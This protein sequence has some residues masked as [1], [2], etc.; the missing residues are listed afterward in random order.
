LIIIRS[1]PAIG[2]R[3]KRPPKRKSL[4]A[5][6]IRNFNRAQD[7]F[8]RRRKFVRY[9][10][11]TPFTDYINNPNRKKDFREFVESL[12]DFRCGTLGMGE[13]KFYSLVA[14]FQLQPNGQYYY[15][16]LHL[17][18]CRGSFVADEY[19]HRIFSILTLISYAISED[20]DIDG[21]VNFISKINGLNVN[22]D[23]TNAGMLGTKNWYCIKAIQDSIKR[24][25]WAEEEFLNKVK[26]FYRSRIRKVYAEML[27]MDVVGGQLDSVKEKVE[28]KKKPKHI[29]AI[30]K[31][32]WFQE[33]EAGIPG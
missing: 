19:K 33:W 14:E 18:G 13:N 28:T 17:F 26:K 27:L 15:N 8:R 20:D 6:A 29:S 23:V 3:A 2:R 25:G 9:M 4:S 31:E 7:E 5:E 30:E 21:T 11:I 24:K 1:K 22:V 12:E 16:P 10:K 32:P